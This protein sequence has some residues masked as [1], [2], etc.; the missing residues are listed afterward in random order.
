[1]ASVGMR[2]GDMPERP[3]Q[4]ALCTQL[5]VDCHGVLGMCL[6]IT[7]AARPRVKEQS[8][9]LGRYYVFFLP[10]GERPVLRTGVSYLVLDET[11]TIS[12]SCQPALSR[13]RLG[14]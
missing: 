1:M 13:R 7:I 6:L 10:H 2:I 12:G 11:G 4:S 5:S 8:L 14:L 9:D 3:Y